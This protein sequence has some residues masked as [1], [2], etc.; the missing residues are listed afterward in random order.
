MQKLKYLALLLC[1]TLGFQAAA[2]T[3]AF[4]EL[5]W[6]DEFETEGAL[7]PTW[8]SY[9][10]GNGDN[11]WG[12]RELQSYTNQPANVR[13]TGGHLVIEAIKQNGNWTSARVKTQGKF[14][15][16]YG[17]VEWRA[18]LAP[19]VGTWPA[20]WMLGES[21]TTKGWPASGEIDVMEYIDRLPGKVQAALHSP[22][23]FGNT[24]HVGSTQVPDATTA[25]HVYAAEWSE[26]DIKFYVDNTLYYTYAPATKDA[27]TW[28]FNE[29]FFLIM[30]IAVGG[31]MGSEPRL[32]T[33]GLKNGIDPA[34]TSTRMEV[35]YVRVYQ[36]FKELS[37]TGPAVVR[38]LAQSITF[39]TSRLAGATYTWSLPSGATVVSG[40]NSPEVVVN[41][42]NSSGQVRVQVQHNGQTFTKAMNV[43]TKT[44]PAGSSFLLEGFTP[45]P[46]S[47]L[48]SAGGTF[49]LSHHQDA[50]KINYQITAPANLPNVV[51]EL[52]SPVDLTGYPVLAAAV[53]TQNKS[54]TVVLRL[55]LIDAAGKVTGGNQVFSLSPLIDDGEYYTYYFNY[56]PT[57]GSSEG[58][59]N[60]EEISK[61]RMLVNYGLLGSPG[62]DSLWVDH[63]SVLPS[64]PATPNRASHLAAALAA[65]GVKID[66]QDNAPNE[67]GFKVF[68][69]TQSTGTYSELATLPANTRT[70]TDASGTRDAFYKVQ[71]FNAAGA[72]TFSNLATVAGV[73]SVRQDQELARHITLY[74]NPA[75]Q[76]FLLSFPVSLK[77]KA[78]RVFTANG[79]EI[80]VQVTLSPGVKSSAEVRPVSALPDGLYLCQIE[81]DTSVLTKR[82][83]IQHL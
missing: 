5:V 57:F 68:K 52:E 46:G 47:R 2:Q 63:L 31:N 9:D 65:S 78:V 30:N 79:Q 33:N 12:N 61:I 3:A 21:V 72:G 22:S 66:W 37:L 50:L 26:N 75:P 64:L 18:K 17:R 53:K 39:K 16:T 1:L 43:K 60:P 59:V 8:W 14:R 76:R 11:G 54:R 7:N 80:P 19:G 25:F 74:P 32:E 48:T 71:S 36:Q 49:Q 10:L 20:L 81:T 23:S 24:Q 70:F 77:V 6:S 56:Q 28:P 62:Q 27:R 15:F 69:A 45:F 40:H 35:D 13:Q 58:Q 38:P 55:D 41:W 82:L 42:G 67:Q 83:L 44:I 51:Y 34:L 73:L 29:D 4:Q